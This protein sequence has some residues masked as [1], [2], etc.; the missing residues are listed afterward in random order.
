VA[1]AKVVTQ[2]SICGV[3]IEIVVATVVLLISQP[4]D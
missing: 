3:A 2:R 4:L 1:P